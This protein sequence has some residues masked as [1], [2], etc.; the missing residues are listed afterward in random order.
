MHPL[1]S[2]ASNWNEGEMGK[3]KHQA[4]KHIGLVFACLPAALVAL[5]YVVNFSLDV[6]VGDQ[7]YDPIHVVIKSHSNQLALQDLFAMAEGHRPFT[8][9]LIA[10][11]ASHINHLA[12]KA[13]SLTAWICTGINLALTT[14]LLTGDPLFQQP[15]TKSIRLVAIF[16]F[17]WIAFTI[18]DQEG[19]I[20]YY[21]STWQLA[22]LFFLL[23]CLCVQRLRGWLAWSAATLCS[24]LSTLSLG[25]GLAT[26][27]AV[28]IVAAGYKHHR[29]AHF[30]V[31]WL[32]TT[33]V[34]GW[35]YQ[36]GFAASAG[37]ANADKLS[38]LA[39]LTAGNDGSLAS[40]V[41]NS[42]KVVILSLSRLW[43]P[44]ETWDHTWLPKL[45][46]AFT[47]LSIL[48]ST[49]ILLRLIA[50]GHSRLSLT[51]AGVGSFS[52][53]GAFLVYL[54]RRKLMPELR[55]SA[56]A[57]AFWLASVALMIVYL[58]I[59]IVS[60]K[61]FTP[62]SESGYAKQWLISDLADKV[63]IPISIGSIALLPLLSLA[64]TVAEFR[65][66]PRFDPS[67]SHKTKFFPLIRDN[68]LRD[69]FAFIDER[70][71]Y[72]L[73]L[74]SLGGL[75]VKAIG[76]PA[77]RQSGMLITALPDELLTAYVATALSPLA[78]TP[79]QRLEQVNPEVI[80]VSSK[81]ISTYQPS[82]SPLSASMDWSGSGKFFTARSKHTSV[83]E[84][85]QRIIQLTAERSPV[86]IV[87]TG[88]TTKEASRIQSILGARGMR[89]QH[90][91]RLADSINPS[92]AIFVKCFV[93][94][95]TVSNT[96]HQSHSSQPDPKPCFAIANK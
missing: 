33:A 10:I 86:Y 65:R 24:A 17:S 20:D 92:Q 44:A 35:L 54:S 26:W 18:H 40:V 43:I 55:H 78:R 87:Y 94:N 56:G 36:S 62:K 1:V 79:E 6:P 23:A 49:S 58:T 21:F 90:V 89:A 59:F 70:S 53:I 69:C 3:I 13:M 29:K 83:D 50:T 93:F 66:S 67:C 95:F 34:A 84:I 11:A 27:I 2:W 77:I 32:A 39:S 64:K 76:A 46:I 38:S 73:S 37:A 75:S 51:W 9:R 42:A 12:P 71:V 14:I 60:K 16:I 82:I 85:R 4:N 25:I 57:E 19:W 22:L 7:W 81:Q 91:V 45:V 30:L 96:M 41:S 63:L 5:A 61:G 74:L 31:A 48:T 88:T 8:I 47:A 68:S 28:P 80:S 52:F 15:G 72:Q